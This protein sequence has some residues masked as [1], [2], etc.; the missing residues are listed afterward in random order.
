M[1]LIYLP[2][3]DRPCNTL[4]CQ[5]MAEAAGMDLILLPTQHLL[6]FDTPYNFELIRRS[7]ETSVT[8]D[9]CLV[10]SIDQL[11]YGGLLQSR[12]MKYGSQ[13]EVLER[14]SLLKSLKDQHP[15][16]RIVAFSII[17]RSS[18]AAL[19]MEDIPYYHLMTDYS[20]TYHRVKLFGLEQ[21]KKELENIV[22]K[23]PPEILDNYH[24]VRDR[25]HLVNFSAVQLR[26]AGV[27]DTLALLQ[28]DTQPYGIHRLEQ[29]KLLRQIENAPAGIW[30]HNG[31]DEGGCLCLM[32]TALMQCG[33]KNRIGIQYLRENGGS[34]IALYEDRPFQENVRGHLSLAGM[35][36]CPVSESDTVLLIHTPRGE[37]QRESI[38]QEQSEYTEAE[39]DAMAA[40]VSRLAAQGKHVYLLDVAFAN[41][42]DGH[43][44]RAISRQSGVDALWGY[45]GWNTA[46]NSL[47]TIVAQIASDFLSGRKN[48]TFLWERL[49]D[50]Y[51]YQSV[52]RERL[53]AILLQ[54]GENIYRLKDTEGAIA[55]LRRLFSQAVSESP[56]FAHMPGHVS[57]T[58]PWERTFEAEV[59]WSKE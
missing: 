37:S 54:K 20:Q 49:L 39:L 33:K 55:H 3:D 18:I 53:K 4:F 44:L 45:S 57:I 9:C 7:L 8:D 15:R 35:E 27:L 17:M 14:L 58:L 32:R 16:M 1:R 23:L 5:Q 41:G 24:Q 50:D 36:A 59:R 46:G 38:A 26:Q 2:M 25:N 42:G 29:E 47:G 43:I 19:K 6:D 51:L 22:R 13:A 31:A 10:L 28:E 56:I 34:F 48:E 52:V 11:C 12:S 30:V 21:D 40:E